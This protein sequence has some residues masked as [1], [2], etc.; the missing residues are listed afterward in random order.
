MVDIDHFK[1]INDTWGHPV[2]DQVIRAPPGCSRAVR[3]SDLIG[4][5]GGEEFILALPD[6]SPDKAIAVIDRIR[7]TSRPCPM[8]T[9]AVSACQLQRRYR[10]SRSFSTAESLTT[11]A[12]NALL[13]AK[14]KGRN[15]STLANS[16]HDFDSDR[17]LPIRH[18]R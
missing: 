2:G 10:L 9:A 8:R 14:H 15:W 5:Y 13:E 11:A 7:A 16:A 18:V 6:A 1:S 12:D 4:R 17:I 3:A